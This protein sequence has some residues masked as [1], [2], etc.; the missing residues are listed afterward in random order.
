MVAWVTSTVNY[1][2]LV[3]PSD[4]PRWLDAEER[5]TWQSMAR[6]LVRLRS[7]LDSELQHDAG[8]SHFDYQVM[9]ALS[10]APQRTMRLSDVAA[11][12]ESSLP[13]LSQVVCRL[14][15]RGWLERHPDPADGR[16]TLA[17]LTEEGWEKIVA[18][19]PGHVEAVRRHVFDPL[20]KA[21]QR[22]L[23]EITQ[24][25]TRTF[26]PGRNPPAGR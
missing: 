22:Q 17:T 6:I 4:E 19:A 16:T 14:E 3:E 21:Q 10:E 13:R 26:E 9:A 25:I 11:E 20:T 18:S 23:L 8:I 2:G 5:R 7:A 15:K 1:A 12:T 24:R